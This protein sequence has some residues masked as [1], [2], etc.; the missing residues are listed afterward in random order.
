MFTLPALNQ[1]DT[2]F[3]AT[4][5]SAS[6]PEIPKDPLQQ[7]KVRFHSWQLF[8]AQDPVSQ[9]QNQHTT[10]VLDLRD[11]FHGLCL[12]STK[13]NRSQDNSPDGRKKSGKSQQ[14]F[15]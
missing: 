13:N 4:A 8:T 11:T 1:K 14:S 15:E 3:K 7:G 9:P 2:T 5:A 10:P 12:N 6:T